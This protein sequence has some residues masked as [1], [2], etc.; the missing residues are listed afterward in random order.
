MD[1]DTLRQL[2][3]NSLY[4]NVVQTQVRRSERVRIHMPMHSGLS[5]QSQM[6]LSL[7]TPETRTRLARD[8]YLDDIEINKRL[9]KDEIDDPTYIYFDNK[10]VGLYLELWVC[11]NIKCPGCNDTLYKYANSNMPVVDVRCINPEHKIGPI[12]YQIKATQKGTFHAGLKYFSYDEEYICVGSYKYGHNCHEIKADNMVDRDLLIGYICI[13]YDYINMNSIAIDMN[14]SF[15]LIP[16]LQF[17]PLNQRQKEWT[18][19]HYERIAPIP[20]IKFNTN[21]VNK[22]RFSDIYKPFGI[23]KL[24]N[25]Y[26]AIKP[27]DDSTLP[28]EIDFEQKYLIMKMKYLNLKKKLN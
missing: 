17:I 27:Y 21:M 18:Y 1:K 23:I 8:F 4:L 13:E 16:N 12:F 28:M 20:V 19:Y 7:F 15:V 14:K 11:I 25:Q 3:K 2:F 6:L 5:P 9:L 24:N 22:F 10:G 26:D